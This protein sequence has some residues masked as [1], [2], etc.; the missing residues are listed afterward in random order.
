MRE[1]L[2]ATFTHNASLQ[3]EAYNTPISEI[4]HRGVVCFAADAPI[5][6]LATAFLERDLYSA[7]IV[8][9]QW[10]PIGVVSKFELLA[11]FSRWQQPLAS[12]KNDILNAIPVARILQPLPLTLPEQS[13]IPVAAA[14]MA[15]KGIHQMPVVSEHGQVSGMVS[16]LDIVHWIAKWAQDETASGLHTL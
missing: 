2:A 15:R 10:R 8:D 7:P 3:K 14:L 11:A 13:P 9:G 5:E 12:P 4:M 16:T 1:P 6:H